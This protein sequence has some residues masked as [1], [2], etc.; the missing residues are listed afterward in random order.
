MPRVTRRLAGGLLL[1]LAL[2]GLLIGTAIA[3]VPA[4]PR[5]AVV[6]EAP[7]LQALLT[8]DSD[9]ARV[10]RIAGGRSGATT[11]PSPI[12][13]DSLSWSASGGSIVFAGVAGKKHHRRLGLY[14]AAADGTHRR[15]IPG[16]TG[17]FNPVLSPDGETL[18]FARERKAGSSHGLT[19]AFGWSIWLL[20]LRY[21]PPRQITPWREDLFEYPSSFSPDGS[22]LAITRKV[23]KG[24]IIRNTALALH[25]DGGVP[26][27]IARNAAEP[28]YSPDGTR[29]A[30]LV[31]ARE[32]ASEGFE[33]TPTEL[34]A[35][36]ADGSGLTLLTGTP[37]LEQHPS[38]DPSGR[39]LVYTQLGIRGS[40]L[41]GVGD[42]IM[43]INADGTCRTQILS[44]AGVA[45]WDAAWQPGPGREAGP[46][47]C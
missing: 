38:W 43:E 40:G 32:Q 10:R 15:L 31:T 45:F 1:T 47:S 35:A 14:V 21:G 27:L 3:A 39:R 2:C 18:A 24:G 46:I 29:L 25:P 5:L 4:G 8:M 34:A 23:S 44:S 20:N 12:A 22:T 37:M 6:R 7:R 28:T 36:S 9:G 19:F 33:F 41:F 16:T 11:A 17:G 30:L 26:T 13:A 42:S